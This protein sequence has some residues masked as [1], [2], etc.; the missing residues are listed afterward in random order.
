MKNILLQQKIIVCGST[1]HLFHE[2]HMV[3][4][5]ESVLLHCRVLQHAV[6]PFVVILERLRDLEPFAWPY[7]ILKIIFFF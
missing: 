6:Q 4:D 7:L 3:F 1:P 5:G 2:L